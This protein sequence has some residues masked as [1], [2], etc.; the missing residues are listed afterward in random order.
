MYEIRIH[1]RGG[2]GAV[3]AA[4]ILAIAAFYKGK[5]S[6]AFPRFGT[7]RRGAPVESFTRIDTKTILIRSAV[8]RPDIVIV[9]DPSLLSSVD[10][11]KGLKKNGFI[12]INSSK[13]TKPNGFTTYHVD[14]TAIAL[15][16][17]GRDIVNTAMLGALAAVSD[18]IDLK[19][20]NRAVEDRFAGR[21]GMIEKNKQ[22]IKEVYEKLK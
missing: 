11:T 7:E 2:Q 19:S 5:K 15:K 3:T 21:K 16:I 6:Q 14:A 12:I 18:I 10:V 9:L 4:Q 1:G 13:K 22:A 8:Y 17:F 20:L